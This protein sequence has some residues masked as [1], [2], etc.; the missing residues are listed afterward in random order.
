MRNESYALSISLFAIF[1]ATMAEPIHIEEELQK[2]AE[3][4][5]AYLLKGSHS[6]EF[7]EKWVGE[8]SGWYFQSGG[9]ALRPALLL[10]ACGAVSGEEETALPAAAAVE[11]FHTWTLIHDDWID[12]DKTRRGRP[13]VHEEYFRR[14]RRVLR[15]PVEK[16]HHLGDTIAILAGDRLH[17]WVP[18]LLTLL[19]FS[20]HL[21]VEI[22]LTLI[23]MFE[24]EALSHILKGEM[25]DVYYSH[26][27]IEKVSFSDI[28]WILRSKTASL[29]EYS[30]VAG[31]L[32]GLK[33]SHRHHPLVDSLSQFASLCGKAFQSQDD[34][35]NLI[36][37]E[38][39][40]GKPVGSDIREGKKTLPLYYAYQKA[41]P[42]QRRFLSSIVGNRNATKKDIR[43]AVELILELQG[44]Q[45]TQKRANALIQRGEEFLHPL[46]DSQYKEWLFAWAHY[47][48]SRRV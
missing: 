8:A 47:L 13:T 17:G 46:P 33:S 14:W 16:A 10:F 6:Y 5:Q 24:G 44:V 40:L 11:V 21:P 23:Q 29:F 37:D 30:A 7:R 32:I 39:T 41:T 25:A 42:A 22:P 27:P 26:R 34:I 19:Y 36:G 35:L 4:V 9:K 43:S 18:R 12:R 2:R 1:D 15:L 31:A 28:D 45:R 3:R 38:K 48:I 20:S